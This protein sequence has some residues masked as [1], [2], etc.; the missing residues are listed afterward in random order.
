MAQLQRNECQNI[1]HAGNAPTYGYVLIIGHP[2]SDV[3]LHEVTQRRRYT[4]VDMHA[5]WID[6]RRDKAADAC[7]TVGPDIRPVS[8]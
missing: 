4:I 3:G 2:L 1:D 7:E 8:P 6:E 5:E